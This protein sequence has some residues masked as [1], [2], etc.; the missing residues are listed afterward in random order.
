MPVERN[1]VEQRYEAVMAVTRNGQTVAQAALVYGVSRQ[2]LHKWVRRYEASGMAG[3]MDVSHR[4]EHS[5]NRAAPEV[6]A[7]ACELR[8]R[9]PSWG[10]RRIV[11]ELSTQGT[12]LSRAT[13]YRILV[14]QHLIEPHARRRRPEDYKRWERSRPMELWQMDIVGGIVLASGAG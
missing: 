8:R 14:R 1:V 9:H 7:A 11:H 10:P 12:T 4:P 13:A 5:P 2:T 6:E 3:L